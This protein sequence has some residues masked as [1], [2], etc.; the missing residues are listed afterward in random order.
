VREHR[1]TGRV[2]DAELAHGIRERD[3]QCGA[4]V[5]DER[6][7]DRRERGTGRGGVTRRDSDHLA[8]VVLHRAVRVTV[9]TVE[10]RRL[11]PDAECLDR[12]HAQLVRRVGPSGVRRDALRRLGRADAKVRVDGAAHERL[13]VDLALERRGERRKRTL[14]APVIVDRACR[15]GDDVLV[16]IG[17]EARHARVLHPAQGDDRRDAH[18]AVRVRGQRRDLIRRADARQRERASVAKVDVLVVVRREHRDDR[19]DGRPILDATEGLGGEESYARRRVTQQRD[20]L[21]SGRRIVHVTEQLRGLRA[22]LG[23]AI[24]EE[25]D[26]RTRAARILERELVQPPDAVDTRELVAVLP[27]DREQLGGGVAVD[28]LE[29]RLL[30]NAHVGVTEQRDEIGH[31]A[32]LEVRR[33]ER[34][35]LGARRVR[36]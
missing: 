9:H 25:L 11:R 24:L 13:V 22:D 26:E 10:D 31:R 7:H 5:S 21:R 3:L 6:R 15:L 30:T 8:R 29:L 19:L 33:D 28:E 18:A 20:V 16:L 32:R 1:G 27:R 2:G 14:D 23:V 12:L 35:H 17:E 4:R 36:R 34:L